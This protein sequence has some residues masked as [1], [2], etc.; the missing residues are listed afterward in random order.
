MS[1]VKKL[2]ADRKHICVAVDA[3][4]LFV[5]AGSRLLAARRLAGSFPDYQRI[6]PKFDT[7][8]VEI[9]SAA[10]RSA[11]ARVL[12]FTDSS[13]RIDPKMRFT[14]RGGELS[15]SAASARRRRRGRGALR[16]L[17]SGDPARLQSPVR[18]GVSRCG[19]G[20]EAPPLD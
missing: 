15:V 3:Q 10:L 12:L 13:A 2:I 18:P 14:F 4:H 1:Q 7:P 17:R 9:D 11:I 6:L 20:G 8:P 19:V 16:L 5:A